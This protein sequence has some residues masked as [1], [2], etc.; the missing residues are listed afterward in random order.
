MFG[1]LSLSSVCFLRFRQSH[2]ALASLRR[3]P[4]S[5]PLLFLFFTLSLVTSAILLGGCG[6]AMSTPIFPPPP[7]GPTTV[8]VLLSS[9]GNDKLTNFDLSIAN[10]TLADKAG[11]SVVLYNNPNALAPGSL[12]ATEFMHLNGVSEPLVAVSVPQGTY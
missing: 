6:S 7:P 10:I 9:T 2:L 5:S 8:A 1:K 12:S 3:A 4:R 11:N